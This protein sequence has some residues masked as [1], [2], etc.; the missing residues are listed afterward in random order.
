MVR[1]LVGREPH[2]ARD[3]RVL[4][5]LQLLHVVADHHVGGRALEPEQPQLDA[6]ALG[7][8]AGR[9]ARRV[10]R[11]HERERPLDRLERPRAHRRDVLERDAQQAVL[12]EVLD[13]GLA[14]LHRQLVA[15][16]HAQLPQQVVVEVRRLGEGVLD[17]RDLGDLRRPHAPVRAVVEVVLEEALDLDLLERV[18]RALPLLDRLLLRDLLGRLRL[19]DRDLLEQRVLHHLLLEHL[20]Q[21]EGRERQQLDRLLQRGRQDQP[22]RQPRGEAELLVECQGDYS[23]AAAPATRGRTADAGTSEGILDPRISAGSSIF[24]VLTLDP[25]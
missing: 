21:L 3:L 22:L 5:A 10:E 8:A 9:D 23:V 19:L 24:K 7:Q 14:D 6:Q 15:D 18:L 4:V 1:H 16:R 17:R 13:D 11:L 20:G 25:G 2:L 12:V